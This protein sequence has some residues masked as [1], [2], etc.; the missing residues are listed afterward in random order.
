MYMGRKTIEE[1][2]REETKTFIF[3]IDRVKHKVIPRI[4]K[5]EEWRI[6]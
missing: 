3:P 1:K 4:W 6:F 2:R 5:S